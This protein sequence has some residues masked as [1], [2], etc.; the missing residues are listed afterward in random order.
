MGYEGVVSRGS[1]WCNG[2]YWFR[3]IFVCDFGIIYP[4]GVV[5]G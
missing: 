5:K 2:I 1:A 4:G 3:V